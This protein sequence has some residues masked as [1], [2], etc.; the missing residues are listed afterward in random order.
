LLVYIIGC[1]AGELII[2]YFLTKEM[3]DKGLFYSSFKV[4]NT[5]LSVSHLQYADDTLFIGEASMGNLWSLKA[6]LRSF[7]LASGLKVNFSKSSIIGVN[8]S[9]E[10]LGVAER[11]LHY[12]IGSVPFT[13]LGLPV[14]ANHRKEAT[15]QPLL[16][17]LT[18]CLG[19]W[20]N[21]Y[22]SHGG[23]VVLLNSV[24][25]SPFSIFP[26]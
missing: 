3:L 8:V 1:L 17:S 22:V 23:W 4:G 9:T 15:W 24:L 18:R 11:F 25:N 6:I 21:R 10:F 7:E 19:V 13:Y 14:G 2:F 20:G 12:K 26:L 16:D 5:S